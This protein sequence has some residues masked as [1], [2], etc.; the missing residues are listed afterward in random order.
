VSFSF[1]RSGIQVGFHS[2][3]MVIHGEAPG[4]GALGEKDILLNVRI[5]SDLERDGSPENFAR[6]RES[7]DRRS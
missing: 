7:R 2:S 6:V 3:Q 5:E 4:S 1:G